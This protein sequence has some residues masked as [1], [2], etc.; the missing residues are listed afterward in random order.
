MLLERFKKK[1]Q[2]ANFMKIHPVGAEL[3]R[4][5]GGTDGITDLTHLRVFSAGLRKRQT[6]TPTPVKVQ[7]TDII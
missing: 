2:I 4:A 6:M 7:S 3:F 5:Y 1:R